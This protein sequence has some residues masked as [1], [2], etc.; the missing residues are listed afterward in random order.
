MTFKQLL[1]GR[2]RTRYGYCGAPVQ[3]GQG[4]RESLVVYSSEEHAAYEQQNSA[5]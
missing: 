5:L 1:M 2:L 4:Y 3:A